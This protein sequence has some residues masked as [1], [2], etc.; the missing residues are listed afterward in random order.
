MKRIW[1]KTL[2]QSPLVE[3]YLQQASPINY[4]QGK[5][6]DIPKYFTQLGAKTV[7]FGDRYPLQ[8][9]IDE[10]QERYDGNSYR[11]VY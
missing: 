8:V 9:K 3:G 1:D 7:V 10:E 6:S 4:R 11:E 2:Q 5:N